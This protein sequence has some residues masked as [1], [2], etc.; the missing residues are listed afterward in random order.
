MKREF[1]NSMLHLL[2]DV[3]QRLVITS[4]PLHQNHKRVL[5]REMKICEIACHLNTAH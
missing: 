4:L 3:S 2:H 5:K 1:W